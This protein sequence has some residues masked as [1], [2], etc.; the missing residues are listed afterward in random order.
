MHAIPGKLGSF[1]SS[2]KSFEFYFIRSLLALGCALSESRL[3]MSVSKALNPRIGVI[4]MV[5]MVSSPGI[6]HAS[7]AYLPSSFAMYTAMLGT[8][9]SL[10]WRGSSKIHV[11]LMYFGIGG[12]IGWPFA[13]ALV[14]PFIIEEWVLASITKELIEFARRIIDGT[15]RCTI[16]LVNIIQTPRIVVWETHSAQ[17]LQLAVETFF[18]HK[19]MVIPFN[20]LLYNVRSGSGRGPEIFGTESWDFYFRNMLLNFHMWFI[21]ALAAGPILVLQ[22]FLGAQSIS[23][24]TL[25]RCAFLV[26]PLYMWLLIFSFQPHKEERF[27]FPAYGFVGLNGAIALHTIIVHLGHS[28]PN[29]VMG[30]FSPKLKLAMVSLSVLL[31]VD[32]GVLRIAGVVSAYRAPLQVYSAL[33]KSGLTKS[34]DT[35]CLGKE[36]HRFPGSYHLPNGLH[37]KF[38]RSSFDGLLPGEFSEAKVGFGFFGGTWLEPPGMNDMN[39]FD[40]GKIIDS[41]HCT[42]LIDTDYPDEN[43]TKLEP[44]YARDISAWERIR[45]FDFLDTSRTSTLARVFWVPDVKW[46]PEKHRRHWGE[47]CLLKRKP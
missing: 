12:I 38:I 9:N 4:F 30:K 36:W 41:T 31:A 13:T 18:Y 42:F 15:I 26:S 11:T 34:S 29:T 17:I 33:H 16:V 45:C 28:N 10:D 25:M 46:W 44:V 2:T 21:L 1:F 7:A 43:G 37:A 27:M 40:V 14:A 3:F 5:I 6:F 22:Y 24:F 20:L 47:Y 35:V 32:A 39:Q 19:V 23:K 8:A